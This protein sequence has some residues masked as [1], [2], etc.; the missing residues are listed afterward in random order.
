MTSKEFQKVL[1]KLKRP[2]LPEKLKMATRVGISPAWENNT[3]EM[4]IC[5]A[6]AKAEGTVYFEEGMI[7]IIGN[8]HIQM[9][10]RDLVSLKALIDAQLAGMPVTPDEDEED[11]PDEGLDFSDKED[12]R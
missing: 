9:H 3:Q 2:E 12:P 8:E 4:I 6:I 7:F 5:M 10:N 11:D 1:Q